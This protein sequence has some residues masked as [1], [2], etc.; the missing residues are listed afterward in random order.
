MAQN[1]DD[2][3]E[4][5]GAKKPFAAAHIRFYY[6]N[7]F[8]NQKFMYT[9][10]TSFGKRGLISSGSLGFLNLRFRY[11]KRRHDDA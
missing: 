5:S 3:E 11:W 4:G 6:K 8:L 1:N 7:V 10:L 9:I 2:D